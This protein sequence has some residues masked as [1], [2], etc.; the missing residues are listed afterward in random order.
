MA[1]GRIQALTDG[2]YAIAMTI[3]ILNL[4]VPQVPHRG[5]DLINA[6]WRLSTFFM[7]FVISFL[8]LAIFWVVH[9]LHFHHIKRADRK[10]LW[11]NLLSLLF[12]VLIP[13]TTSVYGEYRELT[14]AAAFFEANILVLGL[15]KCAQWSYATSKHLLVDPDLDQAIIDENK[16]VGLVTPVVALIAIGVAFVAPDWSTSTFLLIPLVIRGVRRL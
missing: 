11:I 4:H 14:V 6:L 10:L 3:L 16:R 8:L 1:T 13:F 15:I 9:H 2:V 12:V 5:P 7:D